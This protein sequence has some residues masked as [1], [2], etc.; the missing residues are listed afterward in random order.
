GTVGMLLARP[1]GWVA[2]FAA[3]GLPTVTTVV[4]ALPFILKQMG[5]SARDFL[6]ELVPAYVSA[7]AMAV[8]VVG[9]GPATPDMAAWPSLVSKAVIGA[10][11]YGATL[12]LFFRGWTLDMMSSLRRR[13]A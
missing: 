5:T 7:L 13:T 4:F 1:W 6:G 11:V 2:V 10:I 3:G 9:F 12:G 8:A